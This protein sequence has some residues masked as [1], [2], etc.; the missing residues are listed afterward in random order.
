M[1]VLLAILISTMLTFTAAVAQTNLRQVPGFPSQQVYDLLVDRKGYLWIAHELGITRYDGLTFTH[2]SHPNEASLGM[3]DLI[4]DRF[5]RI[6]CHNFSSQVFYVENE[7]LHWLKQYDH[8]KEEQ[9]PRMVLL[10]DELV[11]SSTE[12]LFICDVSS[13]KTRYIR[14]LNGRPFRTYSIAKWNDKVVAYNTD[15][16]QSSPQWFLY[17]GGGELRALK[18][19]LR[20]FGQPAS[21]W[22]WTLRPHTYNDTIYA[23][24]KLHGLLIKLMVRN[25]SIIRVHSAPTNDLVNTVTKDGTTLW[26]NTRKRSVSST[27]ATIDNLNVSDVVTGRHGNIWVGSIDK[28]LLVEGKPSDAIRLPLEGLEENDF[29]RSITLGKT[30]IVMG[31]QSGKL[32]V[33]DKASKK[34]LY[35]Q[36]LPFKISAIDVVK[37]IKDD[38]YFFST[39]N[40]PYTIDARRRRVQS[41]NFNAMVKDADIEKDVLFMATLSGLVLHPSPLNTSPD[42]WHRP[43]DKILR[44]TNYKKQGDSLLFIKSGRSDAVVF[45]ESAW[46]ILASFKDGVYEVSAKGIRPLEFQGERVYASSLEYTHNRLLIATISNGLL[47]RRG[48]KFKRIGI[49]EGLSSNCIIDTKVVGNHLWLFQNK[50]IQVLDIDAETIITEIDL[51][52]V[53]GST[54]VDVEEVADTAL[55]S[56]IEGVFKVPLKSSAVQYPIRTY[57]TYVLVNNKDTLLGNPTALSYNQSDLQIFLSAPWYNSSQPV[58]FKYRLAGGGDDEWH[59]TKEP[60]VQ[61]PSLKPGNYRFESYAMHPSGKRA[62]NTVYFEFEIQKPWWEQWWF[63]VLVFVGV[64]GLFY[65]LYCYRLNQ[66]LKVENIRRSISSDL[67][68]DIGATLSSINIYTE[69]AKRQEDNREFLNLIQDNIREIIG[70]LDDLVWSINPKNDSCEQLINRMRSF[71]EPLLAGANINYRITCSDDL[72]KLKLDTG[73][74]RNLY[75]IFKETINNVI[76]HSRSKNCIIDIRYQNKRLCLQIADDGI[77]FDES[78]HAKDRNGLKNI[79]DRARQIKASIRIDSV[80]NQGTR[81]QLEAVV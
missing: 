36:S 38:L 53:T 33:L 65:A 4:E 32:I 5:G 80:K 52:M 42:N 1:R 74:K 30:T 3:T 41:L 69:L 27:G 78:H 18:A 40:T 34:T 35:V 11:V 10:E 17:E 67:H 39:S 68:D 48:N 37:V 73:I 31:T 49:N 50:A 55:I 45:D 43:L 75:L 29:V 51:P 13:F 22:N 58:F 21:L 62:E 46:A 81:V 20:Q 72:Y 44:A 14:S 23:T 66:L 56:S 57:I 60:V 8:A 64:V 59:I 54:M 76:K 61:F 2:Y 77:G 6:W 71:S 7:R 12:G 16:S 28:G 26:I 15:I 9:F 25:D 70:K 79:Q 24:V 63:R 47:I 19:N